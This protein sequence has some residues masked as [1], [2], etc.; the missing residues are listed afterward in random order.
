MGRRTVLAEAHLEEDQQDDCSKPHGDER[1]RNY[2]AR[3][4][5]HGHGADPSGDDQS[6]SRAEGQDA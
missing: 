3:E 6:R 2:L 5:R 1:T 4:S